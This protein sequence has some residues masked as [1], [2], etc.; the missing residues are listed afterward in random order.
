MPRR[1]PRAVP[2]APPVE[3]TSFRAQMLAK[4]A[5]CSIRRVHRWAAVGV[6]PRAQGN[7]VAAHYDA[8]ARLALLAAV[9]LRARG[10]SVS[11]MRD[12]IARSSDDALRQ[13]AGLPPLRTPVEPPKPAEPAPPALVAAPPADAATWLRLPLAPGVELHVNLSAAAAPLAALDGKALAAAV[14]N[15]LRK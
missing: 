10:Y 1:R 3:R 9:K 2:A 11:A 6:I 8:R 12:F 14:T 7:G 4:E 15:A 13:T 5:K